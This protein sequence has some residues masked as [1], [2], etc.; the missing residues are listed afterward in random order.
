MGVWCAGEP[1]RVSW[2][3]LHDAGNVR[4]C[5]LAGGRGARASHRLRHAACMRAAMEPSRGRDVAPPG[6]VR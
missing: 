1:V 6:S 5:E 3:E 4:L 2:R